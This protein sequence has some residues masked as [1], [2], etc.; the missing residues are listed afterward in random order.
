MGVADDHGGIA[1]DDR[2]RWDRLEYSAAGPDLAT[3]AQFH[4]GTDDGASANTAVRAN[5]GPVAAANTTPAS[6]SAWGSTAT[7]AGRIT[8][9]PMLAVASICAAG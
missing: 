4:I 5:D 8:P 9:R 7:L 3:T 2:V 1:L 6:T